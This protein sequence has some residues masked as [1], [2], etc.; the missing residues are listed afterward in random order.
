VRANQPLHSIAAIEDTRLYDIFS[1]VLNET[2]TTLNDDLTCRY[3]HNGDYNVY[4]QTEVSGMDKGQ[5]ALQL[6]RTI[7]RVQT[8]TF[9]V[10]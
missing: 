9:S 4:P 2:L 10:E 5:Y 1:N 3:G 8:I 7:S 6:Q